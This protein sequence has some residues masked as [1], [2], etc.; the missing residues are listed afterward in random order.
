MREGFYALVIV[1]LLGGGLID[2]WN[3]EWKSAVL[4]ALLAAANGVFFYWR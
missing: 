2:A 4:A 3:G 1:G